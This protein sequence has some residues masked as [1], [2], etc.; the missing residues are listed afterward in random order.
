MA[1][2]DNL[3]LW[4]IKMSTGGISQRKG[5]IWAPALVREEWMELDD[6]KKPHKSRM[7]YIFAGFHASL[8]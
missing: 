7:K 1:I 6:C 4:Q 2:R 3:M 8:I 5:H